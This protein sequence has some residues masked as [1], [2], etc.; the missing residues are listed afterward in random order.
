MRILVLNYEY[1]PLGGGAS[2]VSHDI[3]KQY[4]KLGHKVTVVTMGFK[5]L[6]KHEVV[7]Q[8]RVYRVKCIRKNEEL[9]RTHEMLSY[10]L[11]AGFFLNK[12]LKQKSYDICHCHFIIPTGVLALWL[13]KRFALDYIITSHGSDVPNYNP[14]RFTFEHNFTKPLLTIICRNAKVVCSPSKY[15][16]KLIKEN[17]GL[18]NVSH[19]PNGIDLD[20][21][22]LN[23]SKPKKNIIL[24]TGRLLYRKGFQTII[25][26]VQDIEIPFEVHIAG[27]GPHRDHLEK[28]AKGSKTKI[29]FHGWIQKGSKELLELYEKAL[30]YILASSN[31]NASISLLEAMAAKTVV[32]TTNTSGCPETIGNAGFLIEY[33]D[34]IKL[35]EILLNLSNEAKLAEIY[36]KKAYERLIRHFLWRDI[37]K[38]YVKLF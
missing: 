7:D 3:A 35:R 10:V 24:S 23:L 4:V 2:S 6:P 27:D 8:I 9:C 38:D 32:I 36:S 20:T 21:F 19:I 5:G 28:M 11:S 25:R 18:S 17:I 29:V 13:K 31:E 15:L 12:L 22:N 33:D 14:D 16:S 1:P 34:D 26:A 30:I 37:V